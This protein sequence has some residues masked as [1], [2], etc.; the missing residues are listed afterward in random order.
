MWTKL[1]EIVKA[2]WQH[3]Q[4]PRHRL[5]KAAINLY[6]GMNN[7][8]EAF[9]NFKAAQTDANFA[10]FVFS[11]DA[12]ISTLQNLNPKFK[13]F[14]PELSEQLQRYISGEN[15]AA[16]ICQPREHVRF[17]IKLLRQVVNLESHMM[18]LPI[19][20]LGNFDQALETFGNFIKDHFTIEEIFAVEAKMREL[21]ESDASLLY[22]K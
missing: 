8:H 14:D 17:Q 20:T 21:M 1:I 18:D 5:A 7:C 13:I 9:L 19:E 12:L 22:T 11:I 10:N 15:R 16:H 4:Q 3:A 6:G 2:R